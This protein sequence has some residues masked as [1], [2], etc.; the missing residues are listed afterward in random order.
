MFLIQKGKKKKIIIIII[1]IMK[2]IQST[3]GPTWDMWNDSY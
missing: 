3:R 2:M 1:I